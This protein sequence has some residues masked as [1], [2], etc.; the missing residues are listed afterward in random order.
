MLIAD[1]KNLIKRLSK[2][3]LNALEVGVGRCVS[4]RQ[5]EITV[6]HVVVAL[7]DDAGSDFAGLLG[8]TAIDAR[9]FRSSMESQLTNLRTGSSARPTFSPRLM[10]WMQD[11]WVLGSINH[12]ETVVTSAAMLHML[13][14]H[15]AKYSAAIAGAGLAA[16]KEELKAGAA[17]GTFESKEATATRAA[18]PAPTVTRHCYSALTIDPGRASSRLVASSDPKVPAYDEEV[19]ALLRDGWRPVREVPLSG[20]PTV[21][22]LLEKAFAT[23]AGEIPNAGEPT[24]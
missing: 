21:L 12:G 2:N 17:D 7:L 3:I 8:R 23:S 4:M 20:V 22:V 13:A 19:S 24:R 11:A 18:W 10:E 5:H 14:V 1:H 15:P 16:V 9:A 6:E